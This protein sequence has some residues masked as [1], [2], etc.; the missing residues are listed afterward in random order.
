MGAIGSKLLISKLEQL[1]EIVG[2]LN[3]SLL[4]LAAGIAMLVF[5]IVQM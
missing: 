1:V 5:Q 3:L 4:L 2:D